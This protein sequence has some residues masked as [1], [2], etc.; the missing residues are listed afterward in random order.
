M[1][2]K[3]E[4]VL[5]FLFQIIYGIVVWKYFIKYFF[6]LLSWNW[7]GI[8][9]M[10][11]PRWHFLGA[12]KH[13]LCV[14]RCCGVWAVISSV[15]VWWAAATLSFYSCKFMD[16]LRHTGHMQIGR[17]GFYFGK[18]ANGGRGCVI[19]AVMHSADHD[20]W[21]KCF[22]ISVIGWVWCHYVIDDITL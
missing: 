4:I 9:E 7:S 6:C 22:L 13:S 2:F 1:L 8:E 21:K 5:S 16:A 18:N 17:G 15:S 10:F 3:C 11:S 20:V 14:S 19:F 12:H